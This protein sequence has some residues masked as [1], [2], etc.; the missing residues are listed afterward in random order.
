MKKTLTA[1]GMFLVLLLGALGLAGCSDIQES[2]AKDMVELKTWFFTSGV[3]NNII[4]LHSDDEDVTF[5]C[6]TYGGRFWYD[7]QE[8]TV[9]AGDFVSWYDNQYDGEYDYVDIVAHDGEHIVGYAVVKIT[10]MDYS[11]PT[12]WHTAEVLKAVTF[13]KQLGK[14]Q[15]VSER[16]VK[17][18]I[19]QAKE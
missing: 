1:I 4:E 7:S 19:A 8:A 11:A 18:L 3:P 2:N 12:G 17:K 13:P 14:Y 10:I 5:T 15:D 16:Q 9:S 6:K